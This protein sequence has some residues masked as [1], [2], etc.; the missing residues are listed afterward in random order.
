M[1]CE[2]FVNFGVFWSLEVYEAFQGLKEGKSD[3]FLWQLFSFGDLNLWGF[4]EF[5]LGSANFFMF[6]KMLLVFEYC[7]L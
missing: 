3:K 1:I 2:S 7:G 4:R 5:L 6:L